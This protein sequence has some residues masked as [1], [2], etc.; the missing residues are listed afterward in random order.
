MRIWMIAIVVFLWTNLMIIHAAQAC[1]AVSATTSDYSVEF[2]SK[3]FPNVKGYIFLR[4]EKPNP[5]P[6]NAEEA[7][8]SEILSTPV[9]N[10]DGKIVLRI[11][12]IVVGAESEPSKVEFS[13]GIMKESFDLWAIWR[14]IG[15][16]SVTEVPFE[17]IFDA[18][19]DLTK[20]NIGVS[21][22]SKDQSQLPDL[23]IPVSQVIELAP[24]GAAKLKTR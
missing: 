11:S 13:T 10:K 3:K 17:M 5:E 20:I 4:K 8:R 16:P 23:V 15:S 22:N 18:N 2:S 1:G 6:E 21:L 24:I 19:M 9:L 12:A 14:C 7:R